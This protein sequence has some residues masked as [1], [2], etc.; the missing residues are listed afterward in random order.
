[1]LRTSRR[2]GGIAAIVIFVTALAVS[3]GATSAL[4]TKRDASTDKVILFASDGM[5]PDL[6]EDYARH[7][8]MPT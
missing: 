4:G 1:M 2:L 3:L 6:M 7:G 5:R 8:S